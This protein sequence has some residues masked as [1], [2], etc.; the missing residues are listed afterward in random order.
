MPEILQDNTTVG[1]VEQ[2]VGETQKEW[3]SQELWEF[4][5]GALACSWHG[6]FSLWFQLGLTSHL[7]EKAKGKVTSQV[8]RAL[9][10]RG[11]FW[12]VSMM[13]GEMVAAK[14]KQKDLSE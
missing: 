13:P 3:L 11:Q 2:M 7:L 1:S 6:K 8:C 9:L 10:E 4:I 5:Q 14:G 12:K